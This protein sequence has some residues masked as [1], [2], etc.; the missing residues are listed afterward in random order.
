ML[1][2]DTGPLRRRT[3]G[4]ERP[5]YPVSSP[6]STFGAEVLIDSWVREQTE[7]PDALGTRG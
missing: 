1:L 5:R 6:M 7:G 2:E 3:L 4:N